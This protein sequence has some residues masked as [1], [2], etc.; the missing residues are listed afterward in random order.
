MGKPIIWNIQ[1]ICRQGCNSHSKYYSTLTPDT[2]NDA[3]KFSFNLMAAMKKHG[4]FEEIRL[5]TVH[6][7]SLDEIAN[8]YRSYTWEYIN[9][10]FTK[11]HHFQ[12]G[13]FEE[14]SGN[15]FYLEFKFNE[16]NKLPLTNLNNNSRI[17]YVNYSARIKAK[18]NGWFKS[19]K[20]FGFKEKLTNDEIKGRE[21]FRI[22]V[23]GDNARISTNKSSFWPFSSSNE[24]INLE[25]IDKY[26]IEN[27]FPSMELII[28]QI[29]FCGICGE[30]S[31]AP[32]FKLKGC[33]DYFHKR[34]ILNLLSTQINQ[35]IEWSHQVGT[36]L[37]GHSC[38]V[39]KKRIIINMKKNDAMYDTI[40]TKI[41]RRQYRH[42]LKMPILQNGERPFYTY[43]FDP[44]ITRQK[45]YNKIDRYNLQSGHFTR[46]TIYFLPLVHKSQ[47]QYEFHLRISPNIRTVGSKILPI[48]WIVQLDCLN[49]CNKYL[50]VQILQT[51]DSIE[52]AGKVVFYLLAAPIIK[53][54]GYEEITNLKIKITSLDKLA[55]KYRTYTWENIVPEFGKD[56]HFQFGHYQAVSE[57]G[58]YLQFKFDLN[59]FSPLIMNKD[60]VGARPVKYKAK[61]IATGW[62]CNKYS[63]KVF[64]NVIELPDSSLEGETFR[65]PLGGVNGI[66]PL[67]RRATWPFSLLNCIK[68]EKVNIIRYLQNNT[69]PSMELII[70]QMPVCGIC[71]EKNYGEVVKIKSCETGSNPIKQN[72]ISDV[73]I[74]NEYKCP[75]CLRGLAIDSETRL[76]LFEDNKIQ[77]KQ[78][79]HYLKMPILQNGEKP[80]YTYKIGLD[81]KQRNYNVVSILNFGESESES[82]PIIKSP[83]IQKDSKGKKPIVEEKKPIE[84]INIR[85][86]EPSGEGTSKMFENYNE[87]EITKI[88]NEDELYRQFFRKN[89]EIEGSSSKNSGE[90]GSLLSK[91]PISPGTFDI[92]RK[93]GGNEFFTDEKKNK[94]FRWV[95]RL[96]RLFSKPEKQKE[97]SEDDKTKNELMETFLSNT[98]ETIQSGDEQEEQILKSD[99]DMDNFI[100]E[101]TIRL[102]EQN[103]RSRL[104]TITEITEDEMSPP[105][106]LIR[107]RNKNVKQESDNES[108]KSK[109][110]TSNNYLPPD[111][112]STTNSSSVS[113]D[114]NKNTPPRYALSKEGSSVQSNS[115]IDNGSPI[116]INSDNGLRLRH[117][118]SAKRSPLCGITSPTNQIL[119]HSSSSNSNLSFGNPQL[120]EGQVSEL[121]NSASG[122]ESI[123]TFFSTQTHLSPSP[124][125]SASPSPYPSY[126]PSPLQPASPSPHPSVSSSPHHHGKAITSYAQISSKSPL[127]IRKPA[128]L[129]QST[130]FSQMFTIPTPDNSQSKQSNSSQ[131]ISKNTE[132]TSLSSHKNPPNSF[133]S[134]SD[135][136]EERKSSDSSSDSEKSVIIETNENDNK[137]QIT[138]I[139]TPFFTPLNTPL[140]D[141]LNI[142]YNAPYTGEIEEIGEE[143]NNGYENIDSSTGE[144]TPLIGQNLDYEYTS[145]E[146]KKQRGYSMTELNLDFKYKLAKMKGKFKR[147]PSKK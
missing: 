79:R 128:G 35:D 81:N 46:S 90:L 74:S 59:R 63:S 111:R 115:P 64:E 68:E 102:K 138:K 17:S 66:V 3:G 22:F 65:I 93:G 127:L 143:I 31:E 39:C 51:Q 11:L 33:E 121:S 146:N 18:Q 61:L 98:L 82:P 43:K 80:T 57:L 108:S 94:V 97:L 126:S 50:D 9:P 26:L 131:K 107:K 130:A 25:P 133:F 88:H 29:P 1:M 114:S 119:Q 45:E 16:E 56:H 117:Q 134:T 95:S 4:G 123:D 70:E 89:P 5:L 83:E 105:S 20:I 49:G 75:L 116:S 6:I 142:S 85:K 136:F 52:N 30:N 7:T 71:G 40:F 34:C 92:V 24:L 73:F 2:A 69:F 124:Q 23:G 86:I 60:E 144:E 137:K 54:E 72:E 122:K 48:V 91:S 67:K 87:D 44:T 12:F 112:K 84:E 55:G 118:S 42:V 103:E 47:R 104:G 58:L 36:Y 129:Q 76:A 28:E 96:S 99:E 15:G 41:E 27:S 120:S 53:G 100:K 109:R 13:H 32:V 8:K 101:Q 139:S 78:F 145:D 21:N 62:F 37:S 125:P 141:P 38:P 10:E 140:N 77:Y 147:K 14:N 135:N 106:S 110:Q 113:L 19:T 132:S